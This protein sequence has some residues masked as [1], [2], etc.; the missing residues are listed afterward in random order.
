[1]EYQAFHAVPWQHG[2]FWVF[3]AIVI[4]AVLFASRIAA[5]LAAMLDRR[6]ISVREALD[7]A[8]RL[9]AEA[10]TLLAQA[11]ARQEQAERDAKDILT[12]AHDE[13]GRLGEELRRDAEATASWRE[14]LAMDRIT[15]AEHAAVT[16]IRAAA[17]DVAAQATAGTLRDGF[18]ADA[19]AGLI[20]SAI[21]ALPAA[22][23]G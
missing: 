4:F 8:A 23:R 5:P 7:E 18:G 6:A 11:R 3:V 2:S 12:A 13:A 19:D 1:M 10:E 20:D 17:I 21:A 15:A 14:R 22:L 16:E 9:K